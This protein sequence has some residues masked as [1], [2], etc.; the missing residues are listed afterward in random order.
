M[1]TLGYGLSDAAVVSSTPSDSEFKVAE[2]VANV[3]PCSLISPFGGGG[4]GG[5][6]GV[7]AGTSRT[8][9]FS[10]TLSTVCT[11]GGRSSRSP[12]FIWTPTPNTIPDG[13]FTPNIDGL[14]HSIRYFASVRSWTRVEPSC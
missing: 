4:S 5:G 11:T 1:T 6:G 13:S 14:A 12:K 2:L 7:G 10:T 8:T 9:S 3:T